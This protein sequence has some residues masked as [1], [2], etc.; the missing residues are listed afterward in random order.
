FSLVATT[1]S[2]KVYVNGEIIL[3]VEL[4]TSLPLQDGDLGTPEIKDAI[5]EP[6]VENDNRKSIQ[7]GMRTLIFH[8]SYAIYPSKP[9]KLEIPS[10]P[11]RGIV[12][13]PNTRRGW[14]AHNRRVSTRSKAIT[15]DVKDVPP[16]YPKDQ[17]F[18][19][20]KNLL[21]IESF[22]SQDPK[23]EVNKATT[24]R[25]E[26]K[27]LGGLASFL[28][29]IEA[30]TQP[31][32]KVYTETGLKVNK[33]TPDGVEAS[34]K[35]SH[36]YMPTAPGAIIIPEQTIFW[37][38]SENDKLRKTTIRSLTF[39]VEGRGTPESTT[40]TPSL[41]SEKNSQAIQSQS[42]Q[43]K[44]QKNN[45]GWMIFA[46][47]SFGLW[48]VSILLFYMNYRKKNKKIIQAGPSK[49]KILVNEIVAAA[50]SGDVRKSYTLLQ[51]LK[52]SEHA[53]FF[54]ARQSG[55]IELFIEELEALLYG[56]NKEQE[57]KEILQRIIS[58]LTKLLKNNEE[59][60]QSLS[61][62]YPE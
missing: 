49:I 14:F 45:D 27:A 11:F 54:E 7:N 42:P 17:V 29:V 41:N 10:I 4:K 20:L 34:L 9:G 61:Q 30:P 8:R 55:N 3:D 35:F 15:I 25:F 56:S 38:D 31:G 47:L 28:P 6:L 51:N 43:A 23:F 36:V 44:V 32:L 58:H 46:L 52:T 48:F 18:L 5:V 16:S 13:D 26:I 33:N 24:R 40:V 39:Q 19:P 2:D 37:W 62:I 22:D 1:N 53:A 59:A 12:A 60:K 57:V 50:K 21:V